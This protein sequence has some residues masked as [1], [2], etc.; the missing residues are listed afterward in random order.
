MKT[1]N[2][3]CLALLVASPLSLTAQEEGEEV[4][5]ENASVIQ[6][7]KSKKQE[8][9]RTIKGRVVSQAGY[10]PLVGVLVQR[11]WADIVYPWLKVILH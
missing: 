4:Q 1:L 8:E 11:N 7:R 9:T 5:E 2:I 10:E 6:I 3:F